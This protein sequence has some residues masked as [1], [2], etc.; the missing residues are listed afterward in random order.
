MHEVS[1]RLSG[2]LGGLAQ[3]W[4][5]SDPQAPLISFL[6]PSSCAA[7]KLY[8]VY[9]GRATRHNTYHNMDNASALIP[10]ARRA[11]ANHSVLFVDTQPAQLSLPPLRS[12]PCHY[13]LPVGIV[14]ELNVQLILNSLKVGTMP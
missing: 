7:N 1:K 5:V 2:L 4:P 9:M 11:A 14:S 3:R 8:S 12:S 6:G 10:F 13:D